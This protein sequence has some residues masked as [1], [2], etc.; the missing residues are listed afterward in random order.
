[1][2]LLEAF[3]YGLPVI[4]G[5]VPSVATL[6]RENI[7]GLLVPPRDADSIAVAIRSLLENRDR[8]HRIAVE[9]HALAKSRFDSRQTAVRFVETYAQLAST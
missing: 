4:A 9:N 2:V 5:D 3:A 1:M 7:N 6:V 8:Y